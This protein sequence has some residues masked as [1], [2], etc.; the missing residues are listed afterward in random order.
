MANLLE[1]NDNNWEAEVLNS[2]IP[3]LVDFWAPWCGPCRMLT[4]TVEAVAADMAGKVKVVKCNTDDAGPV[5]TRYGVMTIPVLMVFKGG[6]VV[7][8]IVG[9]GHPKQRIVERL[10]QHL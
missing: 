8:Q 2:D 5:A 3:V 9:A 4:P 7:D 6:K 10:N 1:V